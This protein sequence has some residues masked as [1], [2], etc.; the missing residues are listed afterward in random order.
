MNARRWMIGCCLLL[1]VTAVRAQERYEA[2][3]RAPRWEI[4]RL[5]GGTLRSA[6]ARGSVVLLSFWATWCRPCLKE[7]EEVP[8]KILQHFEGRPVIFLAVNVN[9]PRRTVAKAAEQLAARGIR[10]PIGLDPYGKFGE[11]VGVDRLPHL[12]LID[13]KGVVRLRETGY[14]PERLD[15]VAAR[16]GELLA[17]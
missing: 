17:E 4:E 3:K 6:D 5:E 14:T 10:F 2:G 12:L 8:A 1:V 15:E 7:L 16:I 11:R 13:R 9:E